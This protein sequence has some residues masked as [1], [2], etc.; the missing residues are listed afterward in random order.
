M[1]NT[2]KLLLVE[3]DENLGF[4]TKDQ[5]EDHNYS[6]EWAKDGAEGYEKYLSGTF[7]LCILDVML[8]KKD[9][10]TLGK[11]LR[12]FDESVP[13]FY[14]TA[15]SMEKD[16]LKGLRTGADDYLT[17]P[18]NIEELVLRI[19]NLLSRINGTRQNG[20]NPVFKLGNLT[21]NAD[22]HI[23]KTPGETINLTKKEAGLLR[24]LCINNGELIKREVALRI[25]WGND[26]YFTGRSMDVF[27]TRLRKYLKADRRVK[28]ENV[29]G[30]G[31]QLI[32]PEKV[33]VK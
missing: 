29:H 33:L 10:F 30:V 31:F 23:L 13:I 6:V 12:A 20:Q 15:K 27:I 22:Q 19:N 4:V 18:F 2:A 8:P 11:Q 5:L 1:E 14:L 17:K 26:D 24:L 21:F 28:I 9:G 32:T 7:D 16:K 25:V 3:D